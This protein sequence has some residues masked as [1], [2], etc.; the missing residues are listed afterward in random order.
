MLRESG[1]LA[2]GDAHAAGVGGFS[3]CDSN[4]IAH[5]EWHGPYCHVA[6]TNQVQKGED[7]FGVY[8]FY[9]GRRG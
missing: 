3:P 8:A 1:A 5:A 7:A 4:G 9:P 2:V 6:P